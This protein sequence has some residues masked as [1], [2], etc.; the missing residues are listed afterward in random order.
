MKH[1]KHGLLILQTGLIK[2][3][4]E[5]EE[6]T[7]KQ[8]NQVALFGWVTLVVFPLFNLV[9]HIETPQAYENI[10]LRL[11][12]AALSIPLILYKH[13][14][15]KLRFWLPI[16]WFACVIYCYPFFMT[17]MTL[18]NNFM[19][20]WLIKD[21]CSGFFLI[22]LL[23]LLT[24]M[25]VLPIGI[26]LACSI[27]FGFD[28]TLSFE[29][30]QLDATLLLVASSSMIISTLIFSYNQSRMEREKNRISSMIGT[31]ITHELRTP[32]ATIG[33]CAEIIRKE[34][35]P[36][37]SNVLSEHRDNPKHYSV[38][39]L[40]SAVKNIEEE[41]KQSFLTIDLL[42]SGAKQNVLGKGHQSTYLISQCIKDALARYPFRKDEE[43]LV[44]FDPKCDFHFRG[45]IFLVTH[46]LFNL[47]KNALYS[48]E[49]AGKGTISIKLEKG[50]F[51]TKLIFKDTGAGIP[52]KNS[53]SYF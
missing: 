19:L 30:G 23:D 4:G 21:V 16:Y 33:M 42:L 41:T 51:F 6:R 44:N 13:W 20:V 24:C 53:A 31:S 9:W 37:V 34:L 46:V 8:G 43:G 35:K 12:A 11:F 15:V 29:P 27:Y 36:L 7:E 1:I 32:L 17:W 2:I 25:I 3:W 28:N 38:I 47:L 49:S 5:L 18:Q 14:P 50:L 26:F 10:G 45:D 48:I 40:F 39:K 52:K 22:I